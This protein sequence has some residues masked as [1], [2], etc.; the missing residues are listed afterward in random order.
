MSEPSLEPPDDVH[1]PGCERCH[2]HGDGECDAEY[3]TDSPAPRY[4]CEECPG[5]RDPSMHKVC[6]DCSRG[7]YEA[8]DERI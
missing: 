8:M 5:Y 1:C 7:E 4:C 6:A 2:E 3:F